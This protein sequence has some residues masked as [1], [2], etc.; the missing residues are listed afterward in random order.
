MKCI[1]SFG[2]YNSF[3]IK[4]LKI[5]DFSE[6]EIFFKK[7][8]KYIVAMDIFK[9]QVERVT[10]RVEGHD[11]PLRPPSWYKPSEW[12]INIALATVW[13]GTAP[14]DICFVCQRK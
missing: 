11:H 6:S 12:N 14:N 9:V 1:W 7:N 8:Q 4:S 3:Q 13:N 5:L 2:K 10:K